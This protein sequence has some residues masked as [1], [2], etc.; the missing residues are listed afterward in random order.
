MKLIIQI[1]CFNEE[2]ALPITLAD[3]PQTVPG[4]D[5]IERLVIDDGST[6]RTVEIAR[7]LGVE[8]IAR[9][10]TNK[11]LAAAFQTGLDAA[12][13]LGADVIVNTDAD[14]QYPGRFI[15]DLVQPILA[16]QS[17]MVIGNRQVHR[18]AEFSL[19]KKLLQKMGSAVVRYVSGTDVPDA[20]S[21]FRAFSREAAL[22]INVLSGYTYTLETIIQAGKNNLAISHV[23]IETNPKLR[24]SRLVKSNLRYVLRSMATLLRLFVLYEPLRTFA[25][26]SVPFL[27]FGSALWVRYLVFAAMG[28]TQEGAHISS[29]IA[30]AVSILVALLLFALG[31]IGDLMA[32]NRRIAEQT[33]YHTKRAALTGLESGR[34]GLASDEGTGKGGA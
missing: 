28:R 31:L 9:H 30:G 27:V 17:D 11:G 33:L 15:P 18:I 25:Y 14:N 7:G 26:L 10:T 20:P 12:L 32:T 29:V 16:G 1:P 6:D 34:R 2:Q 8:H 21:G 4:I 19:S 13:Q 23:P 5:K 24:G 22:R 3:L